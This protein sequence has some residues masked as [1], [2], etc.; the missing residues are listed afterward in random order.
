MIPDETLL[1]TS[2]FSVI[3]RHDTTP[4]GRAFHRDIV[5][6]PGAVVI[7]PLLD[8][9]SDAPRVV[10]IHN[11]RHAIQREL[12][13]LPAGTL[14]PGEPPPACAARE[15][16]EET[17]YRA[18]RIEPFTQFYASPGILTELMHIFV[19]TDLT[20]AEAQPDPGERIRVEVLGLEDAYARLHD[21][22][23]V[24]SKTIATLL[25]YRTRRT[26]S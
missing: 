5:V 1:T 24:D 18:A 13:E 2:R 14:E 15:L 26:R 10:M 11:Y 25:L 20:P 8:A 4:D 9:D 12:L 22:A 3:R 6:H 17:G 23:I 7:L 19:A 21:G 16:I